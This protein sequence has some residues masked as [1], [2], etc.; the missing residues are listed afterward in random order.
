MDFRCSSLQRR[1]WIWSASFAVFAIRLIIK[2]IPMIECSGIFSKE[3]AFDCSES[4]F[5]AARTMLFPLHHSADADA[6]I[7]A[8]EERTASPAKAASPKSCRQIKQRRVSLLS[9]CGRLGTPISCAIEELRNPS[10]VRDTAETR[11]GRSDGAGDEFVAT[12]RLLA[13]LTLRQVRRHHTIADAGKQGSSSLVPCVSQLS[14]SVPNV[15][16][17]FTLRSGLTVRNVHPASPNTLY[18]PIETLFT[19]LARR[20]LLNFVAKENS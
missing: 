17:P 6:L 1:F 16:S 11:R 14:V 10:H 20:R 18:A 4:G 12:D 15:G 7:R 19:E 2:N 3:I 13:R 5:A 9:E 8:N